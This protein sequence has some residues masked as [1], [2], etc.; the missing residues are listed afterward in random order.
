MGNYTQTIELIESTKGT[1]IFSLV[2]QAILLLPTLYVMFKA[3]KAKMS[4]LVIIVVMMLMSALLLNLSDWLLY[5]Y[6]YRQKYA[7]ND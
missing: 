7:S 1:L 3:I 2:I 6:A 4:L 5:L